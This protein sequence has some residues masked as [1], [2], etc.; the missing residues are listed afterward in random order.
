[1]INQQLTNSM[2]P[3]N[4]YRLDFYF[5]IHLLNWRSPVLLTYGNRPF[6]RIAPS[7]NFEN[8]HRKSY[9][10]NRQ[11]NIILAHSHPP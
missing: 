11:S 1:M 8:S 6:Q 3:Q 7:L 2:L 4:K 10:E 9:P 5:P